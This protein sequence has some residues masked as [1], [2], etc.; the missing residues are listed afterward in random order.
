MINCTIGEISYLY[1]DGLF[2]GEVVVH[3]SDKR[4]AAAGPQVSSHD[5]LLVLRINGDPDWSFG[6][7]QEA[8]LKKAQALILEAGRH[9]DGATIQ[10]LC[11]NSATALRDTKHRLALS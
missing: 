7:I 11:E 2:V 4:T 5:M 9:L 1:E 10:S 8:F 6:R 3:F